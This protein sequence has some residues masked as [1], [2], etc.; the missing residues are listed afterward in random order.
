[1]GTRTVWHCVPVPN[2][3]WRSLRAGPRPVSTQLLPWCPKPGTETGLHQRLLRE[4]LD[5]AACSPSPGTRSLSTCHMSS[6]LSFPVS[7]HLL[8]QGLLQKCSPQAP[9][10]PKSFSYRSLPRLIP[11][12]SKDSLC[13]PSSQSTLWV[14]NSQALSQVVCNCPDFSR[15]P[16]IDWS[17]WR[18]RTVSVSS[19]F[20]LFPSNN[21]CSINPLPAQ[22]PNPS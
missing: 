8:R 7:G 6:W 14:C 9:Q 12:G 18:T 21:R 4:G 1:M 2:E 13:P 22:P 15:L 19:L 11:P 5:K 3:A 17:S 16:Q 10:G 20:P